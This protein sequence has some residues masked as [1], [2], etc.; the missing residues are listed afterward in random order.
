MPLDRRWIESH[1]PHQGTMCLLDEVLD[2]D[3]ISARC[4]ASSHRDAENPLR[5]FGRLGAASG[6]EY[7]AQ[8]MAV[9]GAVMA[10]ASGT[11]APRGFLASLRSV[12]MN[13]ERLDDLPD[14]LITQVR[15]IAG[16]E[17]TAMYEFSVSAS[18]RELVNG[19]ATI[20]FN[21]G[22]TR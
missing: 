6:I 9:H 14:D 8:T 13:V 18:Q 5:A 7:A 2:W 11:R 4:R 10:S 3:A 21:T 1:I 16:D 12:R 22:S 15:R 20:A 17:S 19:R